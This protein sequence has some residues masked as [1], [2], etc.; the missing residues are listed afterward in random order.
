MLLLLLLL[1]LPLIHWRCCLCNLDCAW[2]VAFD[3][4]L[5]TRLRVLHLCVFLYDRITLRPFLSVNI[6]NQF[7]PNRSNHIASFSLP[8]NHK[9]NL[10]IAILSSRVCGKKASSLAIDPESTRMHATA[11]TV[12]TRR[13]G[14]QISF[15]L[16]ICVCFPPP[17][18]PPPVLLLLPPSL[19]LI[20][21]L[22]FSAILLAGYSPP[23]L[24]I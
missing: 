22:S 17:Y 16:S 15:R 21:V 4:P 12:N 7:Y 23:L 14:L 11:S 20:H 1:L 19:L 24:C 2:C 3:F 5:I 13:L 10:F 18:F 6:F 9:H 8:N